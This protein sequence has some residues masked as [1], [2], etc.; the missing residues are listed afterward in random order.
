MLLCQCTIV[1]STRRAHQKSIQDE[2]GHRRSLA[3]I[4]TATKFKL[5]FSIRPPFSGS[6]STRLSCT[7]SSPRQP[8]SVLASTNCT[9]QISVSLL[10]RSS[11]KRPLFSD[12]AGQSCQQSTRS[13]PFCFSFCRLVRC[14]NLLRIA[15]LHDTH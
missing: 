11:E 1:L 5:V 2:D 12:S 10:P 8:S 15:R 4:T 9:S 6:C 13:A 3:T 7:T 14:Q